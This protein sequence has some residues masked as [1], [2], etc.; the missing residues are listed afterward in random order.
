MATGFWLR[1]DGKNVTSDI[2]SQGFQLLD[3]RRTA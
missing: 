1:S 2:V 3:R